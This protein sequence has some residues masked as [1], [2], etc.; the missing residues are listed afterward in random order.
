MN[1]K[2]TTLKPVGSYPYANLWGLYDMHGNVQEFVQDH[3][4]S[5]YNIG[6]PQ[7]DPLNFK[8]SEA[9]AK[10]ARFWK[11]HVAKGGDYFYGFERAR[12][13]SRE[14]YYSDSKRLRTGFRLARTL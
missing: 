2:S 5:R 14:S 12:S 1:V 11:S 6:A 9:D 13:A 3:Y 8:V 4:K 7:S 10:R